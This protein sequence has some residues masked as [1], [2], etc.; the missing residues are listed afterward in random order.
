MPTYHYK[1]NNCG[2]ELEIIQKI[3]EPSLDL[4]PECDKTELERVLSPSSFRLKGY[5]WYRRTA[6][7]D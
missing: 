1:C 7:M 6:P 2:H 4:C 5:G 3:S